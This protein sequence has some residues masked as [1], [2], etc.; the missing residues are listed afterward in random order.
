MWKC[1][2]V[3][4]W[5][6]G[7]EYSSNRNMYESIHTTTYRMNFLIQNIKKLL[8]TGTHFHIFTF[9]HFHIF[10]LFSGTYF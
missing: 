2:N 1:E 7:N 5:K 8:N 9:P 4:M 10:T 6:C 3:K